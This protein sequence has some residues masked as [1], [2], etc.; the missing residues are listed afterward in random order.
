MRRTELGL[1][2]LVFSVMQFGQYKY[3][4]HPRS[5]RAVFH[6]DVS[7]PSAVRGD[8]YYA[9]QCRCSGPG[10]ARVGLPCCDCGGVWT[11]NRLRPSDASGRR[12]RSQRCGSPNRI[13]VRLNHTE[14]FSAQGGRQQLWAQAWASAE[15]DADV[16]AVQAAATVAE[17][18]KEKIKVAEEVTGAVREACAWARYL[19]SMIAQIPRCIEGT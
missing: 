2:Q 19:C 4:G 3:P 14:W 18:T 11:G 10:L 17:A 8:S 13:P 1:A 15:G 9:R 5:G 7:T 12:G 16:D 6:A